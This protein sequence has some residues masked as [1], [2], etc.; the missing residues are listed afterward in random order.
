LPALRLRRRTVAGAARAHDLRGLW[1]STDPFRHP[2]CPTRGGDMR[3]AA[4][5][6]R[7]LGAELHID[8]DGRLN[9][10]LHRTGRRI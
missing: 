10:L 1:V 2:S 9:G 7:S 8:N 4:S 6:A 3:C 5:M